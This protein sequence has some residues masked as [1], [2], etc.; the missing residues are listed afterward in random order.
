LAPLSTAIG[1]IYRFRVKGGAGHSPRDLRTIEDWTVERYLRMT[2]GVADVVSMGGLIKRYE[3]NP[4]LAKM[5]YYNLTMQQVFTALG[6]GNANAGGN[7]VEQGAQ[8][9]LIRGIG[10]LRSAADIGN[11]VVASHNGT[12][13]LIKDVAGVIVSAVPRQG[14]V[15]QDDDDDIVNGIVLMRKGENPSA[16]L[17]AL[18]E[19]IASLGASVL[20]KGIK[21]TPFYDRTWLIDTTLRTVFKNLLEGAILVSIILY[22]FLG[23]LRSAGIVA[24][25]IP[26]SLLAT[27]IGLTI[28]GIPAN[29]LSLG[30]MDF[31]I[32]VDGSVIVVENVFRRLAKRHGSSEK[33]TFKETVLEATVQVGRPTLF[34]MLIIIIAHVP[35]FTLQRQ[36][37]RIFAPMAYTVT[38]ALVGSL[39]FSLT[40]V[41]LL[42]FFLLRKRSRLILQAALPPG[43]PRRSEPFRARHDSRPDPVGSH[44]CAGAAAW[45][46][47]SS[48][49]E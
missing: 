1:E 49:T 39:L 26:L 10:L 27:F 11:I 4:D 12:P 23:D 47:I 33:A 40:L 20:P 44:C 36:E 37:G 29:L 16:V 31:G 24:L 34:S 46:G 32:V 14:I 35:I 6:R 30:A 41:P 25:M 19:R 13:V 8:Q 15:G 3:V 38:S 22:L 42:C 21:V 17:T 45:N 48:G 7:Y 18:K 2:P 43:S 9:Y 5:K 28:R